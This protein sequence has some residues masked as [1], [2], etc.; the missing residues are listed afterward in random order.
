MLYFFQILEK[1]LPTFFFNKNG[2]YEKKNPR[3]SDLYRWQSLIYITGIQYWKIWVHSLTKID[4]SY[5]IK[6]IKYWSRR[7]VKICI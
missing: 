7:N 6:K 4:L 3:H 2:V 1:I 5:L